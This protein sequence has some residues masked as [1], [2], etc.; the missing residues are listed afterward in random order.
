MT[1]G[2]FKK[3]KEHHKANDVS[4]CINGNDVVD[5]MYYPVELDCVP[6]VGVSYL[7]NESITIDLIIHNWDRR[8]ERN[9]ESQY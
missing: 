8:F 4:L 3:T 2:E 6:I 7:A 9:W 1:Y 5:E